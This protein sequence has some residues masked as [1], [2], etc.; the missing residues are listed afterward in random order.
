MSAP[1]SGA[2][3]RL[4]AALGGAE[5]VYEGRDGDTAYVG[6]PGVGIVT[7]PV[8]TLTVL[9]AL[10]WSHTDADGDSIE[11]DFHPSQAGTVFVLVRSGDYAATALVPLAKL[12]DPLLRASGGAA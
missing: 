6:V 8:A 12:L 7:V 9:S 2:R 5:G 4:P 11:I 10:P 3:V 1:T